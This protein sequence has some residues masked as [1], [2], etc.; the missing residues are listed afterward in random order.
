MFSLIPLL[1]A[2]AVL[3]IYD[4]LGNKKIDMGIILFFA[5]IFVLIFF[6]EINFSISSY[7]S[8]TNGWII[9]ATFASALMLLILPG[10]GLGDKIFLV[11]TF[12]VYPFWL[13]WMIIIL[14]QVLMMPIFKLIFY[15]KRSGGASLPFY[16]F[17]FLAALVAYYAI[18]VIA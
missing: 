14:A 9:V 3:G 7:E 11:V 16:P 15:F 6:Y 12:F 2:F 8:G 10:F 18:M 1:V 4:I 5:A 17:L 13:I